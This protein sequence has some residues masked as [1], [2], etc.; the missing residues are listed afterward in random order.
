MRS[1]DSRCNVIADE[2]E[3]L[4]KKFDFP[5]Q[6]KTSIRRKVSKLVANYDKYLKRPIEAATDF[7]AK[8]FDITNVDGNWLCAEDKQFYHNQIT[9]NGRV[10]YAAGKESVEKTIHPAKRVKKNSKHFADE[11]KPA[12]SNE[13]EATQ[14]T[15]STTSDTLSDAG[16]WMPGGF[17][18]RKRRY[19]SAK[20]AVKLVS[21]ANLS[22]KMLPRFSKFCTKKVMPFLPHRNLLCIRPHT[23]RLSL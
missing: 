19:N 8:L 4:W 12:V 23:K 14:S 15:H 21:K 20:D 16:D 22:T 7:F 6:T 5:S 9:S 18:S 13:S 1:K 2:L 11:G 3:M 17:N 10:G